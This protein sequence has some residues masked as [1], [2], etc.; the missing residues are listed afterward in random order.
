METF[1]EN[2]NKIFTKNYLI[3]AYIYPYIF[4]P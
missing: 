2:K 1:A 3:S 4:T